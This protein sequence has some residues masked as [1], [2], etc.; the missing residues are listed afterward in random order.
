M[1]LHLVPLF[2]LV[3]FVLYDQI[4]KKQIGTHPTFTIHPFF[5]AP[6]IPSSN[7][8]Q[9][10]QRRFLRINSR[11]IIIS[12]IIYIAFNLLRL[13]FRPLIAAHTWIWM[14]S[15]CIEIFIWIFMGICVILV[16]Q[17]IQK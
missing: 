2:S 11:L 12:W 4:P 7:S 6:F 8:S 5:P 14:L 9:Q 17:F 10:D 15:E 13:L 1:I 16:N 3:V